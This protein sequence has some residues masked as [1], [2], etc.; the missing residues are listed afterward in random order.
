MSLIIQILMGGQTME[1]PV[2][3]HQAI[4]RHWKWD[5]QTTSVIQ[6]EAQTTAYEE[7]LSKKL[8]WNWIKSLDL[9]SI[10]FT[11]GAKEVK[12]EVKCHTTDLESEVP[13]R[14]TD[15]Q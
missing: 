6:H 8:A 13:Y 5:S 1:S 10:L 12:E 2:C 11:G 3:S 4:C 9:T 15:L 14:I 7:F